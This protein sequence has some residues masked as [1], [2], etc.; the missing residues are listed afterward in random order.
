MRLL[1]PLT[2]VALFGACAHSGGASQCSEKTAAPNA[3]GTGV[4]ITPT[5]QVDAVKDRFVQHLNNKDA[6]SVFDLFGPNMREAFP[7]P[8]VGSFVAGVREAKGKVT[9][10]KVTKVGARSGIYLLSAEKGEWVLSLELDSTGK[11]AG[12]K[13]TEPPAPPPAVAT[14]DIPMTLP[15]KGRWTVFWGGDNFEVNKHIEHK[16]QRRAGDLVIVGP[17]GKT[18]RTD[19]KTNKDYYA[20]GQEIL[21][22]ADGTVETVIDG[23]PDNAPGTMNPYFA[24]GNTI[25]VEHSPTL[26]SA[27]AHLQPRSLRVKPGAKVKRGDVLGLCGN[28]GNTSEAHLHFQLQDG[29][30]FESAWGVEAAFK[31][32]RV[33]RNGQEA[34]PADYRLLKGDVVESGSIVAGI[35]VPDDARRPRQGTE[36]MLVKEGSTFWHLGLKS[37]DVVRRVDGCSPGLFNA[38]LNESTY[39]LGSPHIVELER[40]GELF[41]SQYDPR[42]KRATL[43]KLAEFKGAAPTCARADVKDV[44]VPAYKDDALIGLKCVALTDKS[45]F[46]KLGIQKGDLV[47]N[48]SGCSIK[49][50]ADAKEIVSR[51][52]ATRKPVYL[53]LLRD[54][55][56]VTIRADGSTEQDCAKFLSKK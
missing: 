50:P 40:G 12:M 7:L 11:V 18:F 35:F 34:T 13:L 8:K 36:L 25:I 29:P 43:T 51:L 17:E 53:A 42:V 23:V 49:S 41:A 26:F 31:G 45:P 6:Q 47:T 21:A 44:I 38:T 56:E 9:S 28:S 24:T 33:T 39:N 10:A 16:S 19:G 37:G 22:A 48:V 55:K 14:N 4:E 2:I 5:P 54:G 32:V 46:S 15:F 20:Y 27:Y 30:L 3:P 52:S 1:F